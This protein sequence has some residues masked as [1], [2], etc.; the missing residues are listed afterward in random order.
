MIHEVTNRV[1]IATIVSHKISLLEGS[2]PSAPTYAFSSYHCT[3]DRHFFLEGLRASADACWWSTFRS[4]EGGEWFDENID[5]LVLYLTIPNYL[6]AYL[7]M[8]HIGQYWSLYKNKNGIRFTNVPR[9][10]FYLI[11][12][13][14]LVNRNAS[15]IWQSP[16]LQSLSRTVAVIKTRY[17]CRRG[18]L[19]TFLISQVIFLLISLSGYRQTNLA[20]FWAYEVRHKKSHFRSEILLEIPKYH[21]W[22]PPKALSCSIRSWLDMIFELGLQKSLRPSPKTGLRRN[23]I[24]D[25]P[26]LLIKLEPLENLVNLWPLFLHIPNSSIIP[27]HIS[28]INKHQLHLRRLLVCQTSPHCS[29][30][31][32]IGVYIM[33]LKPEQIGL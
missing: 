26:S 23:N 12:A 28:I 9:R 4:Y 20:G 14:Y 10:I 18:C 7:K 33:R 6:Y 5:F 19:P 27:Q 25:T 32:K 15:P 24:L 29:L 3:L 8:A 21:T 1:Y 2:R 13:L 16:I 22:S 11:A 30:V 31:P 17:P